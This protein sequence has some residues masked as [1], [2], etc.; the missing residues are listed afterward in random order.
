[1]LTM[2]A[3]A[4]MERKPEPL[5]CPIRRTSPP[6]RRRSGPPNPVMP[7]LLARN[8]YPAP[9]I[10]GL[11]GAAI[12]G[13]SRSRLLHG[14]NLSDSTSFFN[15]VDSFIGKIDHNF[16]PEQ[17]ADWT[18]LLWQQSPELSI[19]ATGGWSSAR[20]QYNNPDARATGLALLCEGVNSS[21]V[22]EARLGWNR[23]A[24]GFFAEDQS[25]IPNSIGL[26]TGIT[27]TYNG[28][29]PST[30]VGSFSQI[31]ATDSLAKNRVDS[32]WHF[33]DNYSWKSGKH[34]VK[35]GYEFRR[36]TI[37]QV[38]DHNFRGTLSFN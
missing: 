6:T 26:D 7:A 16:N 29:L 25:F 2:K 15:R 30:D 17:S 19:R 20:V 37:A 1:M 36:T 23:F 13:Q 5:A 9:N 38:F 22:N 12:V 31:G 21:Q 32:N 35:F 10:P 8:P 18:L 28:G 33:V 11:I 3:R 14:N 27:T 4:K 24:E 34:D